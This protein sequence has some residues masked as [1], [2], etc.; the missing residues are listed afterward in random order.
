MWTGHVV[1]SYLDGKV[2]ELHVADVADKMEDAKEETKKD[3]SDALSEL[4]VL[5]R[6]G[7]FA[8]VALLVLGH[9][10]G[11][12]GRNDEGEEGTL[13]LS[14][15]LFFLFCLAR[16]KIKGKHHPRMREIRKTS[17]IR[18]FCLLRNLFF[19]KN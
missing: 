16:K 14:N 19:F 13:I 7:L 15:T 17:S 9:G 5:L 8:D 18:T 3:S 4:Q 11:K 12:V 2:V 10:G 6:E 1:G